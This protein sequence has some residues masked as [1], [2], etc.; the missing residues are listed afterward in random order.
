[1]EYGVIYK[2]LTKWLEAHSSSNDQ[3]SK[4]ASTEAGVLA[5]SIQD[6]LFF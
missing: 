4:W 2:T 1:M 3:H 6:P 5:G